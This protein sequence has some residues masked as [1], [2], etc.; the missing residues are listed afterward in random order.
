[1]NKLLKFNIFL[2]AIISVFSFAKISKAEIVADDVVAYWL[3]TGEN[4][5]N[6]TYGGINLTNSNALNSATSPFTISYSLDTDTNNGRCYANSG[7]GYSIS[8][9]GDFSINFW[10]KIDPNDTTNYAKIIEFGNTD[11]YTAFTIDLRSGETL[12]I[13]SY[14]SGW[15]GYDYVNSAINDGN[16]HHFVVEGDFG[17]MSTDFKL[18]YDNTLTD[19][20][21]SNNGAPDVDTSAIYL[22]KGWGDLYPLK[23]L[24]GEVSILNKLVSSDEVDDLYKNSIYTIL[25]NSISGSVYWA[26]VGTQYGQT[27]GT[28]QIPVYWNVCNDFADINSAYAFINIGEGIGITS[29]IQDKTEFIGPQK[30]SGLMN[31]TVQ[32]SAFEQNILATTTIMMS[33]T[34]TSDNVVEIESS[35][36]FYNINAGGDSG[37]YI[38][39]LFSSPLKVEY[40][41]LAS[42]STTTLPFIYDLTDMNYAS[43]SI[44]VYNELSRSVTDYCV[45]PTSATGNDSID[46]PNTPGGFNLNGS[47]VFVINSVPVL[48]S[49]I[50]EIIFNNL[51]PENPVLDLLGTSTVNFVCTPEEWASDS[52]TTQFKCNV[53]L[54]VYDFFGFIQ[55]AIDSVVKSFVRSFLTMFPFVLPAQISNSWSLSETTLLPDSLSWLDMSD[56]NGNLYVTIPKEILKS[57]ADYQF[58]F[59]G[60]DMFGA[61]SSKPRLMIANFRSITPFLTW[62]AF[63]WAIWGA[64]LAVYQDLTNK[65]HKD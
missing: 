3:F 56:A 2:L 8:T 42:S 59:F 28:M 10:L 63:I 36:F 54:G 13:E 65:V 15:V 51:N 26:G 46:I 27:G 17:A 4:Y 60:A 32:S 43:G 33:L 45:T 22:G 19:L 40:Q 24:L 55:R 21:F 52:W 47:I 12:H 1:M 57:E 41:N 9:A 20:T 23:G 18:Y 44:C 34:D 48:K 50:F 30:C 53:F 6:S 49:N 29:L 31:I 16:W 62:I 37:N 5:C 39:T 11:N 64:G 58:M 14:I 38:Q 25:N 61:T 35:P 7:T